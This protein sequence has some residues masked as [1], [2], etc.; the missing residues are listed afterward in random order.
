MAEKQPWEMNIEEYAISQGARPEWVKAGY[1]ETARYHR[2]RVKQ[3]ISE[4]KPVPVEVLRD[5]PDLAKA[6][7][8]PP[9]APEAAKGTC[10]EDA[11]RFLMKIDEGELI[12]GSVTGADGKTVKH[13]WVELPTGYIWEPQT[14]SIFRSSAFK[15]TFKPVED[16]RYTVEEAAIM[17]IKKGYHGAWAEAA[18]TRS[19]S[20]ID[21]AVHAEGHSPGIMVNEAK[22]RATPCTCYVSDGSEL[23]FSEGVI[24]ALDKE[25]KEICCNPRI[26][27]T[28]GPLVERIKKFKEAVEI[29]KAKIANIPKGERL[30]PYLRCMA[31][32]AEEKRGIKL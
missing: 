21:F 1:G 8:N 4:G 3:A 30:A 15:E 24:G 23:C 20:L 25:Q 11:Y 32:E 28:S 2:R 14:K 10:Y 7:P 17:A 31:I 6:I 18:Q 5:Y 16:A 9:I 12:H 13:A 26:E 19:P 27:L 22:A 29:C